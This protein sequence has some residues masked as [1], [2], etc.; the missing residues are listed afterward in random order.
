[1][2]IL[3]YIAGT[4]TTISFLP[5]LFLTL[6]TRQTQGVSLRMYGLFTVGITLWLIYG[7]MLKS[8]SIVIANAVTLVLSLV[9]IG[10]VLRFRYD[11]R[12]R[13]RSGH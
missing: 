11:K 3:G 6:K 10:I 12:K 5:Q 4:I 7:L 2:E 1:M 13:E 8:P 9:I